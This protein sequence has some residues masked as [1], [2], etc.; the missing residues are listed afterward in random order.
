MYI[1][2]WS[3]VGTNSSVGVQYQD[4]RVWK[5]NYYAINRLKKYQSSQYLILKNSE[6]TNIESLYK[7]EDFLGIKKQSITIDRKNSSFKTIEKPHL[8][9]ID[10][11]W[12]NL[13]S[14]KSILE[15]NYVLKNYSIGIV[16]FFKSLLKMIVALLSIYKY[17]PT[18][19]NKFLYLFN[20][21][22]K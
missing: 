3:S 6:L 19:K 13:I 11:F 10:I 2:N 8:D 20:Y 16:D 21:L 22:K 14:E 18:K 12:M 9:D 4:S 5:K 15:A 1:R 17:I 7:I